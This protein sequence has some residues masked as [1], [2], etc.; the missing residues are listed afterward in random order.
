MQERYEIVKLEPAKSLIS[1]AFTADELT[2]AYFYFESAP[3]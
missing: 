2:K 1:R 3:L